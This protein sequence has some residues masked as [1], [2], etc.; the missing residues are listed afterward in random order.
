M[1]DSLTH[2]ETRRRSPVSKMKQFSNFAR[3]TPWMYAL[4]SLQ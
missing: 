4:T 3:R 1:S 2:S